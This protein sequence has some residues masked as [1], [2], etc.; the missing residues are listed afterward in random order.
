MTALLISDNSLSTL[1]SIPHRIILY[2]HSIP[3]HTGH[4]LQVRLVHIRKHQNKC[5]LL[6]T[7]CRSELQEANHHRRIFNQGAYVFLTSFQR[8]ACL[9][10]TKNNNCFPFNGKYEIRIKSRVQI[11]LKSRH[12]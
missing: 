9:F 2:P 10:Y 3:F 1:N 7:S 6:I 5:F 12:S 8:L 11:G 4:L